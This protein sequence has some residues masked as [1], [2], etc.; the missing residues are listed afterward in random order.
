MVVR[1]KVQQEVDELR[2]QILWCLLSMVG[3]QAG[4]PPRYTR[5]GQS[6][7]P[8]LYCTTPGKKLRQARAY[9]TTLPPGTVNIPG[10]TLQYPP[11]KRK[12]ALVLGTS[13]HMVSDS[14]GLASVPC[15]SWASSISPWA[16]VFLQLPEDR[17]VLS[18]RSATVKVHLAYPPV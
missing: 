15:Y 1:T 5:V 4:V 8:Q 16:Q 12:H 18:Q 17:A 11:P 7:T 14:H 13:V 6:S 10:Y 2:Y 9:S 3:L